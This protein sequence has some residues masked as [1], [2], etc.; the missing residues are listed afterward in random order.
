MRTL[1]YDKQDAGWPLAV[2]WQLAGRWPGELPVGEMATDC[3]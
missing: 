1:L 2:G 3:D